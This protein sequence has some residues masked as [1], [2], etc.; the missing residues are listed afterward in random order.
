MSTLRDIEQNILIGEYTLGLLNLQ[1][2]AQA[3]ALMG[4]D[5]QAVITALKWED[6]F[7]GLVDQL[8]PISPPDQLLARIQSALGQEVT[9]ANPPSIWPRAATSIVKGTWSNIT[10]WRVA[11]LIL[12]LATLAYA[13]TA[14][15]RMTIVE[16]PPTQIAVLQ[17]PGLTSTPGWILTI[18]AQHNLV[19]KPRVHIDVSPDSS[20]QLWTRN[21]DTAPPRS[22][23]V[24][25]PNQ[26][27][28]IPAATIGAISPD[29]LFEMTLEAQG[30]SAKGS[31]SG[32]IL[33]LGRTVV[34]S[35]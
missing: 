27:V 6:G 14:T 2:T 10:F 4:K 21:S 13:T 25:D 18:D 34:I 32:P 3:Q 8:P 17:A 26:P 35:P 5:H 22:L 24:I 16:V 15:P 19:L 20:V 9:P 7:L 33:F 29:Q 28:V 23:G 11:S 12:A 31:P 1:E 30:G